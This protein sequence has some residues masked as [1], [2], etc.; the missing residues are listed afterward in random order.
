MGKRQWLGL[1]CTESDKFIIGGKVKCLCCGKNY[2]ENNNSVICND[3]WD[4]Y[5]DFDE[6]YDPF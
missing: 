3:C 6:S 4:K 1:K 2:L 5:N